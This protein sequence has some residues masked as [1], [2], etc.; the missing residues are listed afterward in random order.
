MMT[1]WPHLAVSFSPMMRG[2]VS[3]V[4]PG[5]SGTII[6]IGR[7]GKSACA[8]AETVAA[9]SN[10]IAATTVCDR[11][12]AAMRLLPLLYVQRAWVEDRSIE[13]AAID[14]N[15]CGPIEE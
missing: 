10:A 4:A 13:L 11:P 12:L 3:A 14:E 7:L 5:G 6:L 2:S 8:C 1:G 15:C 9:R